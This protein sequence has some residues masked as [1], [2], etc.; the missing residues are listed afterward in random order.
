MK[1]CAFTSRLTQEMYMGKDR[2]IVA[3]DVDSPDKAM[4]LVEKLSGKVGAYKV[5]LE[6][7]TSAGPGMVDLL[8]S[9]GADRIFYDCKFH[10]IPNTVS[11]AARSAARLGVWMFNVHCSGGSAMMKA[12]AEAAR[13]Q[14][15]RLKV[16][17]P[18]VMGVTVL[19]SIDQQAME[20]ELGIDVPVV[21]H[22]VHLATLAKKS[23]LD[24]VVASPLETERI[25]QACGP[26]FLIVT[27]G[28][29]PAEAEM[30][31]QKRVLTPGEAI[32]RGADYLVIGRPITKADDPAAAA[33]KIAR[34]ILN[35]Q[36]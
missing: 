22:V 15:E 16:K 4:E 19:T 13:E 11:G 23:G 31:D 2:I 25:R 30:A 36:L 14:A 32:K 34:E 9:A 29:R 1:G 6:L 3:L 35:F 28:V 24:G 8:R 27:P 26:G 7:V 10:D 20:T 21:D 17:P 12:A 33:A 5:G 18:L